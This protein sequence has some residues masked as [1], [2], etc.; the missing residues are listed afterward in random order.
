MSLFTPRKQP[1]YIPGTTARQLRRPDARGLIATEPSA[2]PFEG[3]IDYDH[4]EVVRTWR[5]YHQDRPA[6]VKYF[7]YELLHTHE[8]SSEPDHYYKAVRFIRLTRVPRY[9]KQ[10]GAAA[11]G[12]FSQMR[13]VLVGLREKNILF[14][15]LIAKSPALPLVF[16]YGVQG[17]AD[18]LE[19]AQEY[20]DEAYAALSINLDG[21]Y[22]QLEYQP[23]NATEGEH[24]AR[25]QDQWNNIAIA[26]GRPIPQGAAVGSS[27][28]FDGNRTDVENTNNQLE[29]F[30]RG[31]SDKSFM[32][33]LITV[34]LD[35]ADLT[36]GWKNIADTLS[37]VK[38]EID[39]TKGMSAGV[40]LPLGMGTGLAHTTG[41]THGLTNTDTAGMSDQAGTNTSYAA[42]IS[43]SDTTNQG[44]SVTHTDGNST[45]EG[46]S[47]TGTDT[48]GVNA[49]NTLGES[50]SNTQT[51]GVNEGVSNSTA[52]GQT[53]TT[54]TN[55]STAAG[56]SYSEAQGVN[57]SESVSAGTTV[58]NN[59]SATAGNTVTNGQ[60]LTAGWNEGT[61]N[62]TNQGYNSSTGVNSGTNTAGS[63]SDGSS[64]NGGIPFLSGGQ[65]TSSGFTDGISNG[66]SHGSGSNYGSSNSNSS[67][68]SGGATNSY[69]DAASYSQ[70]AGGSSAQTVSNTSS[71]GTSD[72]VTAGS[73]LTNTS[74]QSASMANS[75]TNTAGTSAGTSMANAVGTGTS[76][77]ATAGT[78]TGTST[79]AG[80]NVGAGTSLSNAAGSSVGTA[81]TDGTSAT[82]TSGESKATT[83]STSQAVADGWTA[84][85]ARQAS[86]TASLGV[87]PT[88]T[89]TVTKQTHD[90]GKRTVADMLEAQQARYLDG[91]EGGAYLYQ[92]FLVCPDRPTLIGASS[93]L[94]SAFWGA[95]GKRDR[96]PAP[97][98]TSVI[99]DEQEAARLLKHAATFSSYQKRE[100]VASI[101]EP[102][103]YS[104]FVTTGEASCFCHP[105]VAE[106]PGIQTQT[107]SMPV[108]A[109]PSDRSD[110]EIYLGHVV[111]GERGR[112]SD[113]RFGVS[114]DE[115]NHV[116]IQGVTG[117]GKTTTMLR[118]LEQLVN[119]KRTVTDPIDPTNPHKPRLTRTL[120]AGALVLDWMCSA[121][122]LAAV[123]PADRFRLFSV[124][125]PKIGAF[126]FN[127]LEI[128]HPTMDPTEWLGSIADQLAVS[129]GLG[130][131]G[132]SILSELLDSL[133]TADRL[134]ETVLRPAVI[135]DVTGQILRPA[136]TLAAVDESE[137]PPNSVAVDSTGNRYA[138]VYSCPE[139]S[140]L[141]GLP[142]LAVLVAVKAEEAATIEGARLLG[143]DMRNRIQSVWRRIQYYAPGNHMSAML[144]ADPSLSQREC[145][146]V[147][148]LINPDEGLFTVIETDGLSYES[149]RVIVGSVMLA[150]YR[151][152]M[153]LGA[154][155]FNHNGD[156]PGTYLVLEEAHEVLGSGGAE[157]TQDSARMRTSL[158]TSMFRRIRATGMRLIA[159]TQNCAQIPP[160]IVGQ[161]STLFA[162]RTTETADRNTLFGLLNWLNAVTQHQ[163]EYRYLGEMPPG[164]AIVRLNAQT[165]YLESA[166][167][168]VV[169]DPVDLADVSDEDL[170][171]LAASRK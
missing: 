162:H 132:R 77:S 56:T 116:L 124:S 129:F 154:G 20:A 148:D 106:A 34:P 45:S 10:S 12:V 121:R 19:E 94:K 104:T 134:V 70:S 43:Q 82:N 89:A 86:Q 29:S 157:E 108:L 69:S 128:P 131:Y 25:Y 4:L 26:R 110:K 27:A 9:L 38:S 16:A 7:C 78:S 8:G 137:L 100:P 36:L 155:C 164:W 142:D 39:G 138:N 60:S 46:S 37:K 140:K 101:I 169:I 73:S 31:M 47:L 161:T 18:T 143:A 168:Q 54:G 114:A 156:G 90:E 103:L 102:Y 85:F 74:G 51:A 55:T 14:C 130:D 151:Y 149:R 84:A 58:G 118:L 98:H 75:L 123:V 80:T 109:M 28:I 136:I 66:V 146:N 153:H 135:D 127:P 23:L 50:A 144:A 67:G 91:I 99:E 112:V 97:F 24:L 62:G 107:D 150:V 170:E 122:N 152:G 133:Y 126:R 6:E 40:A 52:S 120:P 61:S 87:V 72:T 57:T 2:A 32:L 42:G 1:L 125:N 160:A 145:L 65:N 63:T 49:A 44:T 48:H 93:L 117:L 139:L 166:P 53:A 111:N 158:Y 3:E 83:A 30:I 15:N 88:M 119:V 96:L 113:I 76:A 81:Q 79:A 59:W 13:D 141:I 21:T 147:S 22:Q 64:V 41:D 95:G 115:L 33:S 159:M 5:E 71:V 68:V 35:V 171:I 17:I 105:P 11:G 163:R 165:S 92:M 167:V